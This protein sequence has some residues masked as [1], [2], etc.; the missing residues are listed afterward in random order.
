MVFGATPMEVLVT[1]GVSSVCQWWLCV[2]V[3]VC[4]EWW[5]GDNVRRRRWF[6]WRVR[7]VMFGC[8]PVE[9]ESMHPIYKLVSYYPVLCVVQIPVSQPVDWNHPQRHF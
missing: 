1:T 7:V 6:D 8:G 9:G 4:V 2:C 5:C 3:C